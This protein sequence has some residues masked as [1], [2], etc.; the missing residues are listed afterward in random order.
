MSP[1]GSPRDER[2]FVLLVVLWTVAILALLLSG[3]AAASRVDIRLSE[4][5]RGEATARAAADAVL[6]ETIL[7]QLR[8]GTIVPGPR[9]F[10]AARVDIDVRNLSG[11]INP[12]LASVDLLKAFLV[13]LG[14]NQQEAESLAAAIVD[15]R[16][17]GPD[18]SPHGAKTPQYL[19]AGLTYSP[20]GRP[21]E[22]VAEVGDVLGMTQTLLAA[23]RPYLTIWTTAEPIAAFADPLVIEALR[24]SGA[25]PAVAAAANVREAQVMEIIGEVS[26]NGAPRVTRRAVVRIGYTADG[27]GWRVLKWDDNRTE[28]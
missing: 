25:S 7:E 1:R 15:W 26:M 24:G 6:S 4:N 5:R 12:N 8:S 17:S 27:R 3:L 22:S 20:P 13:A 14:V 10:G 16:S 18:P 21:F 23:M 19:A 28:P 2:G 11:R 9:R